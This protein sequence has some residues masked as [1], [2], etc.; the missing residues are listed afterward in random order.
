MHT[1]TNGEVMNLDLGSFIL[2][3]DL[4]MEAKLLMLITSV[5]M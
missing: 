2:K 5:T 4:L 1:E 3:D